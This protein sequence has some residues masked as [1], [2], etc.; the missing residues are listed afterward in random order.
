MK[1]SKI[2]LFSEGSVYYSTFLPI[3]ESFISKKKQIF[4]YTLDPKD[5]ILQIKS[6]YLITKY[7]GIKILSYFRF[8]MIESEYL[9]C[10]TPNIGNPGYPYLKP[11]L[12]KNLVHVFHSISDISIY[13]RGSL[14]FYDIVILVGEFQEES[15][16]KLEKIR[17]LKQKCFLRLGA[18][19]LDFLKSKKNN[20]TLLKKTILIGSSWG[21]KGCLRTYGID[22]IK[23]LAK[24]NYNIIVR[25]HPHSLIYEKKFI[26]MCKN[27][28]EKI[29]NITWDDTIS[30]SKS[31]NISDILI[32]DTSSLRFDFF[33]IHKKPVITLE[34]KNDEM[35]GYERDSL[36]K[37]WT[38]YSSYEIGPVISKDSISELEKNISYLLNNFNSEE[39]GCYINKTI[40]N[41]GKASDCIANHFIKSIK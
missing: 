3:V 18:P 26:T 13:R 7:L 38:D 4:Y 10:S 21:T 25:P 16:R 17:Q 41:F 40:Y 30:P 24:K 31:M 20:K 39:V 23:N 9:I 36:G 29:E 12:V 34:I 11:K 15:I 37:N 8:S 6:K 27:E 35:L 33:M 2:S 22:F 28:L 32:S 14:D 19:Y 1:N 5:E